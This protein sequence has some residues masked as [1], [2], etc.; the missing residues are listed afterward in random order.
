MGITPVYGKELRLHINLLY[1][2]RDLRMQRLRGR[3]GLLRRGGRQDARGLLRLGVG[4]HLQGRAD[5]PV[6]REFTLFG[7]PGVSVNCCTDGLRPVIF[8]IERV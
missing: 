4:R 8:R 2:A 6:Q 3:A 7:D 1:C 5:P